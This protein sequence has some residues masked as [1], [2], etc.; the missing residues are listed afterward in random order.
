M[1]DSSS[2]TYSFHRTKIAIKMGRSDRS[3]ESGEKKGNDS[4]S[5]SSEDEDDDESGDEDEEMDTEGREETPDL[6]RN[7]SLGMY[8]G[9]SFT[10][11]KELVKPSFSS[12]PQEM[13]ENYDEDEDEDMDDQ[14]DDEGDEDGDMEYDEEG[15]ENSS[16]TQPEEG[17]TLENALGT[18]IEEPAEGWQDIDEEMHDEDGDEDEDDGDDEG[19]DEEEM[20]WEVRKASSRQNE[21]R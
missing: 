1:T 13:E 3:K 14:E 20:L 8:A 7:S 11:C 16:V 18:E 12:T 15:S 4:P 6:Y 17:D 5:V 19:R 21:V 10:S 2:V 9:V